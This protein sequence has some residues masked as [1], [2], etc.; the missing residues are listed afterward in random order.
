MEMPINVG[1]GLRQVVTA[2]TI[3]FGD[4]VPQ[5][6][7]GKIIT[8]RAFKHVPAPKPLQKN[9]CNH[10]TTKHFLAQSFSRVRAAPQSFRPNVP[11]VK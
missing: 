4:E 8:V 3:G 6:T 7:A 1:V 11:N 10:L 5:N 9:A 2:T